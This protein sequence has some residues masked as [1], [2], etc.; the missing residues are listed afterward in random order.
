MKALFL[1][2]SLLATAAM[3]AASPRAQDLGDEG[4]PAE[5]QAARPQALAFLKVLDA[6]RYADSYNLAGE[7]LRGAFTKK[8]WVEMVSGA[9]KSVGALE[10][11]DLIGVRYTPTITDGPPGTY[12]LAF[13]HTRYGGKDWQE[14][15]VLTLK[16]SVFKVEGYYIVPSDDTGMI[17]K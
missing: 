2:V 3:P 13:Y 9:R 5:N 10:S 11:R 4:N 12:Y 16:Q 1:A 17:T 6:G 7:T 8:E 14:R 15:V